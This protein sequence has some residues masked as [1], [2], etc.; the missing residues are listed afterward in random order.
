MVTS[1]RNDLPQLFQ[2]KISE[3]ATFKNSDLNRIKYL[4]LYSIISAQQNPGLALHPS[5]PRSHCL[6]C[7]LTFVHLPSMLFYFCLFIYFLTDI[8]ISI[9]VPLS[10]FSEQGHKREWALA[11]PTLPGWRPLTSRNCWQCHGSSPSA[12]A[13][14]SNVSDTISVCAQDKKCSSGIWTMAGHEHSDPL[15]S[16][17]HRCAEKVT[18]KAP[19][20]NVGLCPSFVPYRF[21]SWEYPHT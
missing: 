13:H 17:S 20:W 4:H 7:F 3:L 1:L 6:S 11:I 15:R 18:P 19:V 16:C 10:L 9:S 2:G 5:L 21:W 8:C 14:V 12:N